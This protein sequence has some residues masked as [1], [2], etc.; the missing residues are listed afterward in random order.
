MAMSKTAKAEPE[1]TPRD[2][3]TG[4]PA[5]LPRR[6]LRGHEYASQRSRKRPK[7]IPKRVPKQYQLWPAFVIEGLR[8]VEIKLREIVFV[9]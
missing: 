2:A 4:G 3:I 7:G 8:N 9:P 5:T 1:P 6:S